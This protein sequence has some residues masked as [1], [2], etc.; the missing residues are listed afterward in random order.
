MKLDVPYRSQVNGYMCGPATLQMVLA[1]FGEIASQRK[2]RKLM[3]AS[4]A[5][6]KSRGT[7][8]HKMVKAM[9]RAG[10]YV[11]VNEDSTI[12]ELKYFLSLKYPV[13]VNFIEPSEDEGHFA[14]V[15]GYS[16]LLK[17]VVMNDPWNGRDFKISESQFK[18]RWRSRY[19]GHHSWLMVADKKPFPIGRQFYPQASKRS[20]TSSNDQR[21]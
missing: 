17:Q 15:T 12:D 8:N 14:V 11:Y 16:L 6:L 5:E 13:I 20:Q 1:F 19:D 7:A 21:A 10:F 4:P 18:R 9:Q 2:L 3:Q